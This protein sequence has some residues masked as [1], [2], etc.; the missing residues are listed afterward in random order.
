MEFRAGVDVLFATLRRPGVRFARVTA[1]RLRARLTA[2][3]FVVRLRARFTAAR[4]VVRLRARLGDD[5]DC[6]RSGSSFR[7]VSL[8][9]RS[10][11]S[12]VI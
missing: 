8:F 2:G 7:P 1:V 12:S 10:Y 4:F 3:R 6:T 9:Q 5:F 11:A